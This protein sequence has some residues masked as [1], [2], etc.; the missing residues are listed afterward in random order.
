MHIR[1]Q[2]ASLQVIALFSPL[3]KIWGWAQSIVGTLFTDLLAVFF[4]IGTRAIFDIRVKGLHNFSVS[5]STIIAVTHKKDLDEIIVASTLHFRKTLF[6]PQFRMWFAA[7]DDVFERG[8]LSTYF[9]L[10]RF[11][12]RLM[13]AINLSPVMAAFRARPIS[14][15]TRS[16]VGNI[17]RDVYRYK[18][19]IALKD[20]LKA[21]WITKFASLLPSPVNSNLSNTSL[22]DSIS[23]DYRVLHLQEGGLRMLKSHVSARIKHLLLNKINGQLN[24]FS[25]ILDKGGILFFTPEDEH[26][27][28]GQFGPIRSG[29]RRV[30]AMAQAD[31]RI[32]PINITYD[33]MTVG[34]MRIHVTI[35]PEMT[36]LK[37]PTKNEFEKLIQIAITKLGVVN[38]GH[39]GSCCLL[40][41]AQKNSDMVTKELLSREIH[42]QAQ[43]LRSLGLTVDENLVDHGALS[44]R[45]DKF[46]KYCLRRHWLRAGTD[47]RLIVNR[48]AVLNS[49]ESVHHDHAI[50]HSYN[51]LMTYQRAYGIKELEVGP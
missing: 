19:N 44:K 22:K 48:K 10:P 16:K 50:R 45:L 49:S 51:E 27:P 8:F 39:L 26:S 32:L 47:G 5:P 46:I 40:R 11:W 25:N 35:G 28:D 36:N 20:I 12:G 21:Q 2:V 9:Q 23:Y 37:R 34:R 1:L 30:I 29:I 33:S 41:A 17:L 31:V 13:Y 7:R 24:C 14:R 3:N 15:L 38:M 6:H 42:S 4:Y 43:K 18:G